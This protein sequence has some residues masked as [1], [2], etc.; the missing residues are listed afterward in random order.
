MEYLT[1][2]FPEDRGVRVD[3][4]S[5]GRTNVVI[6]LESG[7]HGVTLEPPSD[8][9][10]PHRPVDLRDTSPLAPLEIV[11]VRLAPPPPAPRPA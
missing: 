5:V 8:F 10:P 7:P 1:V 11:F 9:A 4:R 3:G 2:T 6:E